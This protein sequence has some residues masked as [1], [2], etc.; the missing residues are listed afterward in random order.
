MSTSEKNTTGIRISIKEKAAFAAGAVTAQASTGIFNQLLVPIYQITL[1]VNPLLIGLVQTIMRLWD[2]VTDPLVAHWSDNIRTR[3][4]R[5][6]PFV[7]VGGF[8]V[9]LFFPLIWLPSDQWS[10]NVIFGYLLVASLCYLTFHTIYTIPYE[11][12]GLELTDDYNERTR[13]YAFRAYIPQILGLGVGWI[14]AFIQTDF[15]DNT[16]HGIRSISI[17]IGILMLLTALFPA[18]LLRERKPKEI[19]NQ[20]KIPLTQNI[21]ETMSNRPF[22]IMMVILVLGSFM[23]SIFSSMNLYAKIYVLYEGDTKAGAFLHAWASLVYSSVFLVAVGVSSWLAQKYSKRTVMYGAA[24]LT[25]MTAGVKYVCYNPDYPYL[26]LIIPLFAAPIAAVNS[27]VVSAMMADVAYYDF[28]KTGER[29][30]AMFT[31]VASW[32]YKFAFSLSGIVAGALLVI[33]G[34]DESL[35]GAQSDLTKRWLVLG[36]VLGSLIPGIIDIVALK[37]YPLSPKVMDKCRE[38]VEAREAAQEAAEGKPETE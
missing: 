23:S 21:R 34:F 3:W 1:G 11:A 8:L 38:E 36:L 32:L 26:S 16:L 30:E 5:R 4:G 17:G 19:L 13:L 18:I 27:Y 28:W 35:G 14:Y 33:I 22:L 12:L 15:F 24:V 29:R 31:G 37:F 7:F 25:V 6:R 9:A 10:E 20:K 2:A